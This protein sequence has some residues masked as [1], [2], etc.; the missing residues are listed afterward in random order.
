[1]SGP[2]IGGVIADSIGWQWAF[3]INVPPAVVSFITILFFFPKETP[4]TPLFSL[5]IMEKIKRLDPIGSTLL[6]ITLSCLISVLQDYSYSL[7]LTIDQADEFVAAIAG[8]ALVLFL[9]QEAFIRPDL[10][11]M[12][13]SMIR[14][15]A[16][17]SSSVMLFLVFA[18]F[19]NF[20][21]FMSI[22]QQVGLLFF[23]LPPP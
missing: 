23:C 16:V 4:R 18:G 14:R 15:R 11:L 5:S 6:I 17:W 9:A 22:F 13:R 3:W 1:M 20:V 19:T 21:F 2:L 10:A 7:T 8:T 12:P